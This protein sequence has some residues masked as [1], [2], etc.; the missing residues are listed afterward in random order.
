M[1]NILII[2][3]I[4]EEISVL[5]NYIERYASD[6]NE[7]LMIK[8]CMNGLEVLNQQVFDIDI[9]FIDIVMPSINGLELAKII[10]KDN[11]NCIIIFVTT[12]AQYAVNGYE[13]EALDFMVKPVKYNSFEFK[14]RRAIELAHR[15]IQNQILIKTNH[16]K[17]LLSYSD[18][19]YIEVMEHLLVYHTQKQSY[20]V[21]GSISKLAKEMEGHGFQLCNSC[22]LVNLRYVQSIHDDYVVVQGEELKIS[23]QKKKTFLDALTKYI[24]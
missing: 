22:Y 20:E 24:G 6:F 1:I 12:M 19:F 16:E 8:T 18:I 23:K 14:F 13:V 7:K 10:R 3:D 9:F 4:P 21:W 17:V 15:N 2:D 11:Q 5:K